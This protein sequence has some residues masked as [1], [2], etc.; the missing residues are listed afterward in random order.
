M[1]SLARPG[2]PRC[3][4]C[5][6]TP[7]CLAARLRIMS[8]PS[9]SWQSTQPYYT[10]F[11]HLRLKRHVNAGCCD[12]VG[13]MKSTAAQRWSVPATRETAAILNASLYRVAGRGEGLIL[14]QCEGR[15]L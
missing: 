9:G 5:V 8:P 6:S 10:T 2:V 3:C 11:G 7:D 15:R 4:V 13:T 14:G 12:T 1:I